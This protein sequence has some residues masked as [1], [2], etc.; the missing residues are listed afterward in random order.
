MPPWPPRVAQWAPR[1]PPRPGAHTLSYFTRHVPTP[2]R[3]CD[4]SSTPCA[5]LAT[6]RPSYSKKPPPPLTPRGVE[7]LCTQ[8]LV[9]PPRDYGDPLPPLQCTYISIPQVACGSCDC[10]LESSSEGPGVAG[11]SA[12]RLLFP[13][14][15]GVPTALCPLFAGPPHPWRP[16]VQTA[17]DVGRRD[18][19][20]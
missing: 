14:R 17:L 19:C 7:L 18:G 5:C 12:S 2:R 15:L 13:V 1:L 6:R 16:P 9:Y 4:G 10:G 3:W 20:Q 11:R 8:V